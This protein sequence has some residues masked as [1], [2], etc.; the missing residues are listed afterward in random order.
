MLKSLNNVKPKVISQDE[1]RQ[2]STKVDKAREYLCFY[3]N[4]EK[5][6]S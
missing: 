2:H 5:K 4:K 6:Y 3:E 1:W